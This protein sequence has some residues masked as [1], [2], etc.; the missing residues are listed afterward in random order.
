[1]YRGLGDLELPEE[2]LKADRFG[3]RGGVEF[4]L[5]STVSNPKP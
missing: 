4:G 3:V 2:F 5:M 1:M